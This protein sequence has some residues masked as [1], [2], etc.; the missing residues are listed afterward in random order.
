MK[1]VLVAMVVAALVPAAAQADET[2]AVSKPKQMH[3]GV[4]AAMA[5]PRADID[6]GASASPA[7]SLSFG[8]DVRPELRLGAEVRYIKVELDDAPSGVDAHYYDLGFAARFQHRLA[9]AMNGFLEGRLMRSAIDV[10]YLAVSDSSA[11]LGLGARAGIEL[12]IAGRMTLTASAS[13]STADV[14]GGSADWLAVEG[15]L[16]LEF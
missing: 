5:V 10:S 7:V 8:Y 9:S 13:Y 15:G 1:K 11:G 6:D 3:L 16:G 4:S 2:I 12:T 14:Y